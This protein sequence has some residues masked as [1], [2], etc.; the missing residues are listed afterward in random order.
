MKIP[1][2]PPPSDAR[3]ASDINLIL[4]ARQASATETT[5]AVP[6]PD[7]Q[8]PEVW[9]R[10]MF[11]GYVR[12]FAEH[13]KELWQWV[14]GIE[15]GKPVHS[16]VAIW[17]RGGA[18]S[19]SAELACVALAARRARRY[20]LYISMTQQ[21]ADDHVQNVASMLE[22]DSVARAYPDLGNRLIGK[23]GNPRGWRRNRLRTE[24]GFTIDA[25]GLDTASR[26]VKLESQRPDFMVIDDVD[27]EVDSVAAVE[28]KIKVLTKKLL[29]SGSSDLAVLAVQ[30]LV[31]PNSI[32]ARLAD[33]RA[34]FL[35]DRKVS[36]PFPAVRGL[37]YEKRD[38]PSGITR[39]VVTGGQPIWTGQDLQAC[40]QMIDR[41]GLHAFLTE[42]QQE[43]SA[44][45]PGAI[46]REWDEAIH[47][48]TWTEFSTLYGDDARD[49]YGIPRIPA[50]WLLARGQD[51]GTTEAH[52]CATVW[53][54]RPG[55]RYALTDSVFVYR[56]LVVPEYPTPL[57]SEPVTHK[58][59]G[60]AI[61]DA[62][63]HW[64]EASRMSISLMSHEASTAL[65]T[66]TMDMPDGYKLRFEKWKPDRR[67]GIA[68]LQNYMEINKERPHPFRPRLMGRPRF[69]L[70]V[71]DDEGELYYDPDG[72][73]CVRPARTA[74]GLVRLRAEIPAYHY[75]LGTSGL[76]SQYPEKRFDDAIDPLRAIADRFFPRAAPMTDA[77]KFETV[78]PDRL[79][80]EAY[81]EMTFEQRHKA[82]QAR[83]TAYITFEYEQKQKRKRFLGWRQVLKEKY[84]DRGPWNS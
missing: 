57:S 47:V 37:T 7:D 61:V 44:V 26:G 50:D 70:I 38:M 29:P 82:D 10:A 5:R 8:D 58:R 78:L 80:K 63:R 13:H 67:A 49:Y 28:K 12:D 76:E 81:A 68:V 59:V 54:A 84:R 83:Q 22:S 71:A 21:Q 24:S 56:E 41:D 27:S 64:N 1:P 19:T 6:P 65:N 15:K 31:H 40:Q 39:Y 32:F 72:K 79:K 16:F 3:L 43:V 73:P 42:C 46:F 30:N 11:P 77:E 51:W 34:D 17:P 35:A 9:L 25:I 48:I 55:R 66:Y 23:F 60:M 69:Y 33:G 45:Q 53:V 14:W 20:G 62:E 36:G 52:P 75:P 18:K 74:R 4:A 2:K